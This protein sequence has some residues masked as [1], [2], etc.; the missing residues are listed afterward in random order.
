MNRSLAGALLLAAAVL[1]SA[2]VPSGVEA[3]LGRQ[4]GLVEPNVASDAAFAALPELNPAT[5]EALKGARPIL[6]ATALDQLLAGRSLTAAQRASLY[7]RMFVHVDLNRGT[8]AEFNLIP[9]MNPAILAAIK[10]GRPWR[11]FDAFRTAVTA[12]SSQAEA[13]R[14]E[15]YFFIPINLNTWTEPIMDSFASIG[16]GTARWKREF[17]EYR[18]WTSMAQFEREIGK[19]VRNQ[20]TEVTRLARYV[21][22]EP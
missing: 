20:P 22:I 5:I 11:S 21:I 6:S 15:Q 14:L 9:G 12:A 10:A 16:V 4:Q 3:Q 7:S 2:A 13:D 8:D 17:E 18:P 19:Y 1:L